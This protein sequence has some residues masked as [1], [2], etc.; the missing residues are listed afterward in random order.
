MVSL[1]KVGK[2]PFGENDEN[3]VWI[4]K[5]DNHLINKFSAVLFPDTDELR[6]TIQFSAESGILEMG[7]R[8]ASAGLGPGLTRAFWRRG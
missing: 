8:R 4:L 7:R 3:A 5:D 2:S 6:R 1:Q